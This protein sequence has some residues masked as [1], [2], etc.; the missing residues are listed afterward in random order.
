MRA[1]FQNTANTLS[2]T[3][4][5]TMLVAGLAVRLPTTLYGGLTQAGIPSGAARAVATLPPSSAL[6]ATFLGYNPMATL[7]PASVLHLLPAATQLDLVSRS[8]FPGLIA[9]PFEAGL[10]IAFSISVVL[11]LLAA[12]A[13]WMRGQRV[14]Y[15]QPDR[16]AVGGATQTRPLPSEGHP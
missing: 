6:F 11:L 9:G 8:Y 10:R 5:F 2:I 1:T 12:I 13:S 4:I 3:F 7:I 15:E 16:N 14:I